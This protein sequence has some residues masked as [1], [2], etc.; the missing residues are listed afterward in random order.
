MQPRKT[1]VLVLAGATLFGAGI[2]YGRQP[3]MQ[4]ALDHLRDARAELDQASADK[5]GHRVKAIS[6]IN[7]AIDEVQAGIRFDNRH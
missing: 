6:L 3:H 7:E 1:L 2:V 4:A 5:G